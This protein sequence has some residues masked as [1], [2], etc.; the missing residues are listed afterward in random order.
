MLVCFFVFLIFSRNPGSIQEYDRLEDQ[1]NFNSV[2]LAIAEIYDKPRNP[3]SIQEDDRLEDQVNFLSLK[4][5]TSVEL[6]QC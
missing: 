3:G 6:E 5:M 1:V 2:S 4:F